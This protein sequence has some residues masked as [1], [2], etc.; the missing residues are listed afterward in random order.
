MQM[1]AW[2]WAVASAFSP[3]NMAPLSAQALEAQ[4]APMEA[5]ARPLMRLGRVDAGDAPIF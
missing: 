4:C 3:A 1:S 2:F 5:V